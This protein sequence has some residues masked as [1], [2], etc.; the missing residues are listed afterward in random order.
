MLYGS[1]KDLG[2]QA[3]EWCVSDRV[4]LTEEE[5]HQAVLKGGQVYVTVYWLL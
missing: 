4:T 3:V 2:F 1:R 5:L